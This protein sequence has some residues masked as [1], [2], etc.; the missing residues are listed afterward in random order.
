MKQQ[1]L[2][3]QHYFIQLLMVS[4]FIFSFTTTSIAGTIAENSN[5][6]TP[7]STITSIRPDGTGVLF[8]IM[9]TGN[10]ENPAGCQYEV[11]TFKSDTP[12][13]S[14]S[15]AIAMSALLSGKRV[16]LYIDGRS[17][18]QGCQSEGHIKITHIEIFAD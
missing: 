17:D 3:I 8:R 4:A 15:T 5:G 12:N 7:L 9:L 14:Q 16:R 11:Y 10:I 13:Y 18:S 2:K 6:W 1:P